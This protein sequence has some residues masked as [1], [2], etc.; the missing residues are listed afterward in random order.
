MVVGIVFEVFQ[1]QVLQ[2]ALQLIQTQLVGQRSIEVGSLLRH[3]M[4]GVGIVGFLDLS[5]QV[6]TVGNHN[7]NNAHVLGKRE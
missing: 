5:H 3:L 6:Y 1:R 7:E 4:L 2:L